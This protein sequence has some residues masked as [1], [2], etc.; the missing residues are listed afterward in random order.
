MVKITLTDQHAVL[1]SCKHK[2][3]F[4]YMQA[5]TKENKRMLINL[6]NLIENLKS[7]KYNIGL[8]VLLKIFNSKK[9]FSNIGYLSNVSDRLQIIPHYAR[10]YI[11][12]RV[13]SR[14]LT[15]SS[16]TNSIFNHREK[17][18]FRY[19]LS[20]A[21]YVY[22]CISLRLQPHRSTQNFQIFA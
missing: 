1:K 19:Y 15:G 8:Q 17:K 11:N 5:Y 13:Y 18:L 12:S 2:S 14:S 22:V 10:I 6:G 7:W 20:S 3:Y 9:L 21:V 4:L 16:A